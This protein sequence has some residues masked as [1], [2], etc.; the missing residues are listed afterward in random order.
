[1]RLKIVEEEEKTKKRM[2]SMKKDL[3]LK[4]VDLIKYSNQ[5]PQV[6]IIFKDIIANPT[7]RL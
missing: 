6:L 1:L 3:A 5:S 2:D 4:I 7:K